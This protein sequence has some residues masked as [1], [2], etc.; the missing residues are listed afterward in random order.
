MLKVLEQKFWRF[1]ETLSPALHEVL[2]KKRRAIAF[3]VAG[4]IAVVADTSTLYLLKGVLGFALIPA[5]ALAFFAG[6]CVSFLLQKFWTFED[7]SVDTVSTQVFLYFLT[8]A[9]NFFLTIALMYFLVEVLHF[10][11]ILSKIGVALGIALC[12]FFVYS[13]YIFKQS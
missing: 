9:A 2:I 13:S 8:A 11:Y 4:G 1:L 10:W 12:T 7:A 5:V 3:L 6:F